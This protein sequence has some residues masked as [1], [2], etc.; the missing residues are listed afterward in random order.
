MTDIWSQLGN[1]LLG[2]LPTTVLF[3]VLV[4]SYRF[5]VQ[6]PLTAV[7]KERHART[8]GAVEDAKKAI[9]RAEARAAEYADR[10][11]QA[12]AEAYK[13]REAR[14]KQLNAE[15]DAAL[16]AARKAAGETVGRARVELDAEVVGARKTIEVSAVELAGQVVRAVMPMAAGGSR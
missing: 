10:L 6:G 2:A 3:I 14:V 16:E 5:L 1:L 12:R 7:L 4:M 11:R 8:D 13:A 9:E 15:R